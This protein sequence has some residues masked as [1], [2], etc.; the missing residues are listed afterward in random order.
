MR[1]FAPSVLARGVTT[2]KATFL[3][4]LHAAAKARSRRADQ[5]RQHPFAPLIATPCYAPI[6][7]G[8]PIDASDQEAVICI[9][10]LV[11]IGL[12]IGSVLPDIVEGGSDTIFDF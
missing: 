11:Y 3:K 6:K 2:C 9:W 10:C 7:A 12:D 4:P 8:N 1:H 5:T